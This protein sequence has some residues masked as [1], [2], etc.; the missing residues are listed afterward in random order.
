MYHKTT[1]IGRLGDDAKPGSYQGN[2]LFQLSVCVDDGYY[3]SS[4]EYVQRPVWYNVTV[5]KQLKSDHFKKGAT[6][7]VEGVVRP[8]MY[9]T[10]A[11]QQ[12]ISMDMK[13]DYFKVINRVTQTA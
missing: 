2:E 4:N 5:W 10:K 1:I 6:V 11:G 9:T 12:A 7:H 8:R 3:D 13:A